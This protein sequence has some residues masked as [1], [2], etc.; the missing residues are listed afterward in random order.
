MTT[1]LVDHNFPDHYDFSALC[2]DLSSQEPLLMPFLTPI[3]STTLW[4]GANEQADGQNPPSPPPTNSSSSLVDFSDLI[5]VMH[6]A[7]RGGPSGPETPV[8]DSCTCLQALT[9]SLFSLRSRSEAMPIDEFLV[10]FKQAMQKCEAVVACPSACC[11]GRSFALLLLMT[12]QELVTLLLEVTAIVNKAGDPSGKR[13]SVPAI[14][15]GAFSVDD[16]TDQGIISHIILA[17]RMKE[18][19]SFISRMSCQMKLANLDD[20]CTSFNHQMKTLRMA[21]ST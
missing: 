21:L 19:H 12:V 1:T 4:D 17:A 13:G 11:N 6:F 7:K 16:A 2:P 9:A 14:S 15:L 8:S 5:D 10:L 3:S 18:L 20:I